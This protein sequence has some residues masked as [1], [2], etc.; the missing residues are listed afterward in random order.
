MHS[1]IF[2]DSLNTPDLA[3]SA[4]ERVAEA[5]VSAPERVA[6]AAV[7]APE[8]VPCTEY[9]FL[10]CADASPRSRWVLESE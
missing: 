1:P 9:T 8:K 2:I 6:E 4:P 7:T 3:V 10:H 5:A